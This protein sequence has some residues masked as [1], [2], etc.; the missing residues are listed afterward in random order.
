VSGREPLGVIAVKLYTRKGD[1]G[2]THLWSGPRVAK[3]DPHIEACGAVDELNAVL[4]MVRAEA[5]PQDVDQLLRRLQHELFRVGADLAM[6][7]AAEDRSNYVGDRHVEQLE[8]DIDSYDASVPPLREFIL[9][10]GGRSA[11]LLHFARTVCRRA[12]RRV[13]RLKTD[14]TAPHLLDSSVRYLNRLGD[15]LFVLPRVLNSRAGVPDEN[16]CKD[17]P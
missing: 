4:G 3:D 11:A 16:W 2:N 15:L 7:G 9:P 6:C 10:S 13:V 5:L 1:D 14:P 12:E 17:G 8:R